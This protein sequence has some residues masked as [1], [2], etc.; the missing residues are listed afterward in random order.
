M[1]APLPLHCVSFRFV[2]DISGK[3]GPEF[4]DAFFLL[5]ARDGEGRKPF[6]DWVREDYDRDA[7]RRDFHANR[8]A[9]FIH[10]RVLF[11]E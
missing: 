10:D 1:V 5:Y 9:S 3:P 11:R 6:L 8:L 4:L 2:S 7:L